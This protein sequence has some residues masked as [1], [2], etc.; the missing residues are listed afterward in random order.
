MAPK[1][2]K[3]ATVKPDEAN[4]EESCIHCKQ[5]LSGD[6]VDALACQICDLWS[7]GDCI[8]V[9]EEVYKYLQDNTE[10][11]PF[12][13]K[14]CKPKIPE[15]KEMID[16]KRNYAELQKKVS[17]FETKQQ[18]DENRLTGIELQLSELTTSNEAQTSLI[19]TLNE[20]LTE[21]KANNLEGF[22]NLL[23]ANPPQQLMDFISKSVKP[24]MQPMINTQMNE[25]S[26]IELIKH[27]LVISGMAE[28]TN[29]TD[30]DVKFAQMIKD[31]MDLVVEV[32]STSRLQRKE[33]SADPKLLKVTLK[34]MKIRKAIL[35]KATSLRNSANDHVKTKV[36]IRPE[37]TSKQLE[38]SKN[39]S[40][41]L[42][43][44]KT[45]NPDKRYKIYR[46]SIIELPPIIPNPEDL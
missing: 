35:S 26:Q 12:I 44:K 27:N 41:Q 28:N 42:R 16:L 14:D 32:E 45:A 9:P 33:Q 20:N 5:D 7:C 17:S 19:N 1:K 23:D 10:D 36:Y 11:F 15:M 6:D 18:Q 37:L 29:D 38:D 22:P 25:R 43:A 46:G 13:C 8:N 21:M 34:D 30:D 31:E 39:L 40:T 4:P 2:K 3:K 24:M